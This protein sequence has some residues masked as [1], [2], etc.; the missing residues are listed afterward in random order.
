SAWTA[1]VWRSRDLAAECGQSGPGQVNTQRMEA[2]GCSHCGAQVSSEDLKCPSC[3]RRLRPWY[4]SRS[5]DAGLRVFT[6]IAVVILLLWIN[7]WAADHGLHPGPAEWRRPG[8]TRRAWY[9]PID[10]GQYP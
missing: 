3:S 2:G 8:P 4:R 7:G 6:L 10:G 1:Q 9:L 5:L